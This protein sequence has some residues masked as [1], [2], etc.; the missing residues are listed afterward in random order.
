[1]RVV[2]KKLI[3][4]NIDRSKGLIQKSNYNQYMIWLM[5]LV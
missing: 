5:N 1:M 4:I 2:D 3:K